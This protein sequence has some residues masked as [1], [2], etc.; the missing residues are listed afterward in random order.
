M[1][2]QEQ[3]ICVCKKMELCEN[4]MPQKRQCVCSSLEVTLMSQPNK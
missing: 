2:L 3:A 4:L 1:K